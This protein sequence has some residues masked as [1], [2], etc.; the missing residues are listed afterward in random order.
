MHGALL[1]F[2]AIEILTEFRV[3]V[4]HVVILFRRSLRTV[5]FGIGID[6]YLVGWISFVVDK[7]FLHLILFMN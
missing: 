3:S 7:W 6:V 5:I 4:R 2:Q 1:G